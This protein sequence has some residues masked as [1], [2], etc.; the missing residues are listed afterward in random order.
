MPGW[1]CVVQDCGNESNEDLG[2]SVHNSPA[3]GPVRSKWK[4]FVSMHR[5]NFNAVGKF[6]VCSEHFT[7]DCFT[8]AFPMKGIKRVLKPGSVPTI[9]KKPSETLSKRSRRTVSEISSCLMLV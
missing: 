5:K 7:V 1:R 9:W 2:I 3:S 8:R 6:A 4:R